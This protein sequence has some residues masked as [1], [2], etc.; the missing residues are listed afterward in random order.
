DQDA[1]RRILAVEV[2]VPEPVELATGPRPV[3]VVADVLAEQ[4]AVVAE[5]VRETAGSRVQKNESAIE[6]RR[7]HEDDARLIFG[8]RMGVGIDDAHARRL[9]LRFVVDDRMN[10]RVGAD[11]EV[12]G[13]HRPWQRR[14]V[15]AEVSAERAAA[16]AEV[17]RLAR[18]AAL[19][20]MY[21]LRLRQMRPPALHY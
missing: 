21:L 4:P 5:S 9:A 3:V 7:V 20:E 14:C 17:P 12:A 15:G 19:L 2:F 11:G 1:L 6:R 18:A 16:H 8:H 13:L 10:D